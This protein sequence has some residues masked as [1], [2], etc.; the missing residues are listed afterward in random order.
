MATMRAPPP[1]LLLFRRAVA[2]VPRRRASLSALSGFSPCPPLSTH[3]RSPPPPDPPPSLSHSLS[4]F[5]S[6]A[7]LTDLQP[8]RGA[9]LDWVAAMRAGIHFCRAGLPPRQFPY[10]VKTGAPQGHRWLPGQQRR[11]LLAARLPSFAPNFAAPVA[12]IG[13]AGD[14]RR[15]REWGEGEGGGEEGKELR[16]RLG[17]GWHFRWN[18]TARSERSTQRIP[19]YSPWTL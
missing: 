15:R 4:F 10:P 3:P 11:R 5:R 17:G 19:G 12:V 2:A 8:A 6:S 14:R 18:S 9:G 13:G 1:H 7:R 16:G